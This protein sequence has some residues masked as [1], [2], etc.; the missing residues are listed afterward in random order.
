M[1]RDVR[2]ELEIS[3]EG[4]LVNYERTNPNDYMDLR[5]LTAGFGSFGATSSLERLIFTSLD[6]S[7]YSIAK[8]EL[9]ASI[10]LF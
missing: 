10:A 6:E 7:G 2:Y 8:P 5:F 9:S 4:E 1:A 3:V